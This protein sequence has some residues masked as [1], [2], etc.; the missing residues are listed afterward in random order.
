[1]PCPPSEC[2]GL[3]AAVS[4]VARGVPFQIDVKGLN[5]YLMVLHAGRTYVVANDFK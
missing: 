5:P 1:M 3:I 4:F 2:I